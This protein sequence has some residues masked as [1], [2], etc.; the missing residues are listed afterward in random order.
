MILTLDVG[1]LVGYHMIQ[2]VSIHGV[3][4]ID[5]RLQNSKYKGRTDSF[6]LEDVISQDDCRSELM[7]QSQVTDGSIGQEDQHTQKPKVGCH[8]NENL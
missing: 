4:Q 6:A 7:P 3:R 1:L 5:L 2:I 8:W